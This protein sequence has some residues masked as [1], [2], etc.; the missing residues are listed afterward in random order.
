MIQ[1]LMT[2]LLQWDWQ[3][4]LSVILLLPIQRS[5]DLLTQILSQRSGARNSATWTMTSPELRDSLEDKAGAAPP[6]KRKTSNIVFSRGQN[7]QYSG[8]LEP[9]RGTFNKLP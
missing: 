9:P 7:Q 3:Q 5:S 2:K 1:R 8:L 4:L 6:T